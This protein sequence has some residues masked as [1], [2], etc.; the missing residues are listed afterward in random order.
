V[1][2]RSIGYLIETY[3][4]KAPKVEIICYVNGYMGLFGRAKA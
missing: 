1:P 3:T 4:R 2:E